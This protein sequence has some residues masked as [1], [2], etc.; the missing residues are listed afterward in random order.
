MTH[1]Q[2][3]HIFLPSDRIWTGSLT[4][5]LDIESSVFFCINPL[6]DIY[7]SRSDSNVSVYRNFLFEFDGDDLAAQ[8]AALQKL[9]DFPCSSVTFSGGKSYHIIVS[10]SDTLTTSYKAAWNA[11]ALEILERTGLAPDPA[12]KNASRLSRLAGAVRDNGVVQELKS[13]GTYATNSYVTQLVQKHKTEAV[14]GSDVTPVTLKTHMSLETFEERLM[15]QRGLFTKI[16]NA[17]K[18][19]KS[20]NN[21]PEL[22]KLTMWIIDSLGAPEE[23]TLTYLHYAL[24]NKMRRAGYDINK[25]D[26]AVKNA[27]N[28]K[29]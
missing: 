14:S 20:E 10:L 24:D 19:L 12:C 8:E 23:V 3:N 11:L 21:Y 6:K 7:G 1:K 28:Y 4:T 25:L 5:L 18:W 16:Y 27:Y 9:S 2:L 26:V 17:H 15:E 29:F 13:L 22:L